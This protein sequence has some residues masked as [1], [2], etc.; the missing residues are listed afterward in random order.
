[1]KIKKVEKKPLQVPVGKMAD[2]DWFKCQSCG[3]TT[4]MKVLGNYAS[5]PECGKRMVRV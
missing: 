1:M 3:Y 2:G 4:R 5:C